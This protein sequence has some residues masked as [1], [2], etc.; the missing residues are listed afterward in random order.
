[1]F[2]SLSWLQDVFERHSYTMSDPTTVTIA[3]A[4]LLILVTTRLTTGRTRP[5]TGGANVPSMPPYWL[6]FFGH[7]PQAVFGFDGFLSRLHKRYSEGVFTLKL[8][9]S[10]HNFV[11]HPS[12]V[13]PLMNQPEEVASTDWV[14]W[15]ITRHVFGARKGDSRETVRKTEGLY[16]VL[17]ST[18]SLAQM[19][20]GTISTLRRNLADWVTFNSQPADQMDW[21]QVAEADVVQDSQGE[22]VVEVDLME[23]TRTFV[24]RMATP[25]VFGSDFDNNFPD[26]PQ[27]VWLLDKHFALLAA[28][29]PGWVPWRPL[30]LARAAR[31]KLLSYMEEFHEAREKDAN[32]EDPGARWEN[33]EDVS[34]YMKDRG[35][36]MREDGASIRLRANIDLAMLWAMNANSSPL[37]FWMLYEINRDRTLLEKICEEIAPYMDVVQPKNEFGLAV[38]MAPDLRTVDVEGLMEK[39][40]LLKASYVE[41]LRLYTSSYSIKWMAQDTVLGKSSDPNGSFVLEKGTYAHA[42]HELH[43]LDERCYPDPHEWQPARHVKETVD[44][45]GHKTV[46]VDLG[47]IRPYG[48]GHSMCK[49]RAYAARELIVI[50]AALL[51]TYDIEPAGGKAWGNL[52]TVKA[53]STKH[54]AK[55]VKAWIRRREIRQE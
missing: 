3:V 25:S 53:T 10:T 50:T 15:R 44:K 9:G 6:P 47:T 22:N 48:G 40:P 17:S 14:V 49:G 38:W 33:L 35:E 21:E 23:L 54:P 8:F 43:Q 46:S 27:L 34:D 26:F 2:K 11:A 55:T 31:R 20:D 42:S 29:I 24:A 52:K 19:T 13:T 41:T 12:L 5:K 1:M 4:M 36:V 32:G 7:A 30:Q 18:K 37:V 28:N 39:C 45:N 51:S 16:H